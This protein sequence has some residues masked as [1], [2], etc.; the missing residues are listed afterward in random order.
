MKRKFSEKYL[1]SPDTLGIIPVRNRI[2]NGQSWPLFE[3]QGKAVLDHKI[4][5]CLNSNNINHLIVTSSDEEILSYLTNNYKDESRITILRRSVEL[6]SYDTKLDETIRF[7]L[8]NHNKSPEAIAVVSVEYPFVSSSLIDEALDT[9][10]IFDSESLISVKSSRGPYYR[11]NG[12]TLKAILDQDKYT[13]HEREALYQ[14]VG[15]IMV[16]TL[17]AF[18]KNN[19]LIGERVSHLLVNDENSFGVLNNFQFEIF[20][21]IIKNHQNSKSNRENKISSISHVKQN[22]F[23]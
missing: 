6:A 10:M 19:S 4:D 8:K 9:L 5:S 7:A 20:N 14:S 15:G 3:Y 2:Y 22:N 21:L 16:S 1:S 11:H 18:Q 23:L 17:D 13:S 12:R